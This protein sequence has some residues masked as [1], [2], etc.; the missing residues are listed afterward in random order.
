M[1]WVLTEKVLNA[2]LEN[3][4]YGP[5]DRALAANMIGCLQNTYDEALSQFKYWGLEYVNF[6][7]RLYWTR[8][9]EEHLSC[10][11]NPLSAL[12][13]FI[14]DVAVDVFEMH[15]LN[16]QQE[17]YLLTDGVKYSE[18]CESRRGSLTEQEVEKYLILFSDEI[19][20][21]NCDHWRKWVRACTE[22]FN[23][24][25]GLLWLK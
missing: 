10:S 12:R 19:E 24:G 5:E 4:K 20:D 18:Y 23:V 25:N 8:T 2:V 22:N 13:Q 21:T 15:E 6:L 9:D 3:E 17:P 16:I 11:C 1:N 14:A 7:Y